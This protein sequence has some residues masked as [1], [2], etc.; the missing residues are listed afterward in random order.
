MISR[1]N[2]AQKA[3]TRVVLDGSHLIIMTDDQ[4]QMCGSI[5]DDLMF[6]PGAA[7]EHPS[8]TSDDK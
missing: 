8:A 5:L 6:G 3:L 7:R 4:E 1:M 2:V